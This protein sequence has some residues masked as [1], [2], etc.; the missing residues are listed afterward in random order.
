MLPTWEFPQKQLLG[1][2]ATHL[3]PLHSQCLG[4]SCRLRGQLA[5]RIIPARA[6]VAWGSPQIAVA[7]RCSWADIHEGTSQVTISSTAK[8][9]GAAAKGAAAIAA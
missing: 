8:A 9:K 6:S 3:G 4:Q 5:G 1:L 2:H 7:T